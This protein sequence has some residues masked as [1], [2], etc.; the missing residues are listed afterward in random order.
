M[1][2]ILVRKHVRKI[3]AWDET[4][5]LPNGQLWIE[6]H[7]QKI[8]FDKWMKSGVHCIPHDAMECYPGYYSLTWR[9]IDLLHVRGIRLPTKEQ[10]IL[11]LSQT[12]EFCPVT[13]NKVPAVTPCGQLFATDRVRLLSLLISSMTLI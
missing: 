2:S 8:G 11:N 9:Q 12:E 3:A 4:K 5:P 7:I 13:K 6:E 1:A 10:L